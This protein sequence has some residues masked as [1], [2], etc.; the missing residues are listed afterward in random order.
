[1]VANKE[2]IHCDI[3]YVWNVL[4]NLENVVFVFLSKL[5]IRV[6]PIWQMQYEAFIVNIKQILHGLTGSTLQRSRYMNT[7]A[8][9]V[10][11]L[12][13][14]RKLWI[15]SWFTEPGEIDCYM[16]RNVREHLFKIFKRHLPC[17]FAVTL[18]Q[19]LLGAV[20]VAVYG[21]TDG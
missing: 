16:A 12:H 1:L 17:C 13:H 15:N 21:A 11:I 3:L 19:Y 18:Q 14:L 20:P 4:H 2:F 8:F 9:I 6:F 10:S 5:N 7:V